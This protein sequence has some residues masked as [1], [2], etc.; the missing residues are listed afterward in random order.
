MPTAKELKDMAQSR[1]NE[2][3]LLCD[4]GYYDGA[5]YLIGYVIEYSL[6]A[7]ICKTLNIDS[8]LDFGDFSP[9]FKTHKLDNLLI[10]SG[11]NKSFKDDLNNNTDL[12]INW[13]L[14]SDWNEQF[15]YNPIGTSDE[16]NVR[17]RITAL[18][19]TNNG[20]FEWIKKNW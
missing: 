18:E 12:K 20:V 9:A 4:N 7:V 5:N 10:L 14:L 6:K 16:I 2:A 19:N 17:Q 3:K 15:R 13:S 8:Y 1:L 11:L